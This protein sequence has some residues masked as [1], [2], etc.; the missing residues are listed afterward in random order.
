[1]ATVTRY[2]ANLTLGDSAQKRYNFRVRVTTVA[3]AAWVAAATPVLR[4]AT[5]VGVLFGKVIALSDLTIEKSSVTMEDVDDTFGFPDPNDNL[6]GFDK[7]GIAMKAGLKNYTVTL[8]GRDDA[9][10]NV[11][12][13]GIEVLIEGA[14]ASAATTEFITAFEAVVLADN[15]EVP[16][17]TSIRVAS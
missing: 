4:A 6:Y 12:P 11:A 13:D 2:F 1:M 10:Y 16:D 5:T 7:L 15:G 17:I 9:A 14:G 8:P 3:G